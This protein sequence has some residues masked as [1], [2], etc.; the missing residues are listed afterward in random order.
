MLVRMDCGPRVRMKVYLSANSKLGH[1]GPILHLPG[2]RSYIANRSFQTIAEAI[3][4][5]CPSSMEEEEPG[6]QS[7]RSGQ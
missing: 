2:Q 1:G 6:S 5:L 7:L 3:C 4:E